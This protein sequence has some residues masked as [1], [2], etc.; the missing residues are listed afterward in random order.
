M[1]CLMAS[2]GAVRRDAAAAAP[3]APSVMCTE[4]VDL[5]TSYVAM[6]R[7]V[8]G[9]H[10]NAGSLSSIHIVDSFWFVYFLF[11]RLKRGTFE[12][13]NAVYTWFHTVGHRS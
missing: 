4:R 5:I 8:P 13:M 9:M 6:N 11:P 1:R 7:P 10:P 12:L 3:A 2:H